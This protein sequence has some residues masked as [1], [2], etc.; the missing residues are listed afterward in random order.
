MI[1]FSIW[2]ARSS[3]NHEPKPKW[4]SEINE[5]KS[6]IKSIVASTSHWHLHPPRPSPGFCPAL[7]P[8]SLQ[9]GG[10]SAD[11]ISPCCSTCKGILAF[12]VSNLG[13]YVRF[14]A[15]RT[16]PTFRSGAWPL[17]ETFFVSHTILCPFILCPDRLSK[18]TI[19]MLC[20]SDHVIS[21]KSHLGFLPPAYFPICLLSSQTLYYYTCMLETP[22]ITRVSAYILPQWTSV[23][24]LA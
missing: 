23:T 4:P 24:F 2:Q 16:C 20:D 11:H 19:F 1:Y 21:N 17:K 22:I 5:V 14:P 12:C 10:P 6:C 15:T 9:R 3:Q 18:A 8:S 7:P 13:Y